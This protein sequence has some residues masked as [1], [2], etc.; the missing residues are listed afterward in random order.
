MLVMVESGG[1]VDVFVR[2]NGGTDGSIG[3]CGCDGC[4]GDG[5]GCGSCCVFGG[6]DTFRGVMRAVIAVIANIVVV[7]AI[8]LVVAIA[9]TVIHSPTS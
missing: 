7:R 2:A 9:I 1:G 5:G 4:G 8:F 3:L 6:S